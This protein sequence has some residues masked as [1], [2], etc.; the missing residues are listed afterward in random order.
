MP[1]VSK[2]LE[3]T[4]VTKNQSTKN[5]RRMRKKFRMRSEFHALSRY[6]NVVLIEIII[7]GRLV[8]IKAD[9][10]SLVFIDNE[11]YDILTKSKRCTADEKSKKK[12]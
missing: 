5:K 10:R 3:N 1:K 7:L 9:V 11:K 12:S 8:E 6:I 4:K 2:F